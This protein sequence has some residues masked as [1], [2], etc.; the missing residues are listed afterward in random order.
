MP[1]EGRRP[2]LFL[3]DVA[4]VA[5]GLPDVGLPH[6]ETYPDVGPITGRVVE[7]TES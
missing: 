7:L 2:Y 3:T 1:D 4:A 6:A 5:L